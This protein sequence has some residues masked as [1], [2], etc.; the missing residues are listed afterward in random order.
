M[1]STKSTSTRSNIRIREK[2][3]KKRIQFINKIQ[4]I[5]LPRLD[6]CLNLYKFE[7]NNKQLN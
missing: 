6:N 5:F 1:R 2:K 3:N 7:K 4:N